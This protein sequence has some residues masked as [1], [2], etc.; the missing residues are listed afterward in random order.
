VHN[1]ESNTYGVKS[2]DPGC[3]IKVEEDTIQFLWLSEGSYRFF[4]HIAKIACKAQGNG[5]Y[6]DC[7]DGE[8]FPLEVREMGYDYAT[9]V[10]DSYTHESYSGISI[11]GDLNFGNLFS[12]KTKTTLLLVFIIIIVIATIIVVILLICCCCYYCLAKRGATI[13]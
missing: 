7:D 4:K 3:M 6:T 8:L 2:D 12:K 1:N 13:T 5:L 10:A 9:D 11:D